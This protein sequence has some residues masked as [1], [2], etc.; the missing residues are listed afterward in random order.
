VVIL[1]A[2]SLFGDKI[3]HR[4][5]TILKGGENYTKMGMVALKW[6]FSTIFHES[7]CEVI[8]FVM[9]VLLQI[10]VLNFAIYHQP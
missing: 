7:F 2:F 4:K 8:Q 1:C 5:K 3:W 10:H 6:E 9:E